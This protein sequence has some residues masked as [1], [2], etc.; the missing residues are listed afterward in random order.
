MRLPPHPRLR[1]V[2]AALAFWTAVGLVFALPRLT[3]SEATGGWRAALLASLVE[4]WSWGLIAPV[5]PWFDRRLP[6]PDAPSARRLAAHLGAGLVVTAGF[7]V[8]DAA[9]AALLGLGDWH[10]IVDGR[11][12]AEAA[13][14]MYLWELLVYGLIAGVWLSQRY[15]RRSV[16]A[17]LALARMERNFADARLNA[18]RMQLDPHFLFN[19]LNTISAHVQAEPRQA[20]QMIEHLGELLR[21]TLEPSYRQEVPLHE[22]LDFLEHYLAIQRIRFGGRLAVELQVAPE[23]RLALVPSLVLQPLVENAF[24]HGLAP[25]AAGGRVV[26]RASVRDAQLVV[27]VEDD[28]VGLPAGWTFAEHAGIGLAVTRERVEARAP[29]GAGVLVVRRGPHGGTVAE[30]SLPF[31]TAVPTPPEPGDAFA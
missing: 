3:A 23:A 2:L 6:L 30:I 24:R 26:V 4:W 13:Q 16:D 1:R 9:F 10:R 18:L 25:R 17:E 21:R 5:V 29:L 8:L 11:L 19:A 31:R 12:V 14:G 28:G 22:E 27:C 15:Y 20:R 7:L